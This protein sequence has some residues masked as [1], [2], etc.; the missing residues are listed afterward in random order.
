MANT[1]A[2]HSHLLSGLFRQSPSWTS[3]YQLCPPTAFS[4][5]AF[6]AS[7]NVW[8]SDH[9]TP[10]FSGFP[11]HSEYKPKA[12]Q[13]PTGL[14]TSCELPDLVSYTCSRSTHSGL[15]AI[16]HI[17]G[18]LL[19]QGTSCSLCLEYSSPDIHGFLPHLQ[20]FTRTSHDQEVF[21]DYLA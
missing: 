19:S 15:L 11:S 10:P 14:S 21:P 3:C 2:I 9:G 13:G 18:T 4:H 17:L 5:T 1:G 16:P 6:S 12:S 20:D 7:F 8:Q